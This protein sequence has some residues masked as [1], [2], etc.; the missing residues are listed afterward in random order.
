MQPAETREGD[1]LSDFRRFHLPA[2]RRVSV[3]GHMRA[4][5]VVELHVLANQ[6]RAVIVNNATRFASK[7]HA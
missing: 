1:H 4:V 6:R 3:E 5:L 7:G 2:D